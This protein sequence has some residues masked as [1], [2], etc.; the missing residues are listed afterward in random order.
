MIESL[1][2]KAMEKDPK[3]R[4]IIAATLVDSSRDLRILYLHR[5]I[6]FQVLKLIIP[7]ATMILTFKTVL[8]VEESNNSILTINIKSFMINSSHNTILVKCMTINSQE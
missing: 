5:T 4:E 2:T 7:L 1:S 6:T 8:E 3:M